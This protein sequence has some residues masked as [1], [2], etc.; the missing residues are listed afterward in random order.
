MRPKNFQLRI[1]IDP[2]L[3]LHVVVAFAQHGK[4]AQCKCKPLH[5]Y[6]T[7]YN[8][9]INCVLYANGVAASFLFSVKDKGVWERVKERGQQKAVLLLITYYFIRIVANYYHLH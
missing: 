3:D 8:E 5:R 9:Y 2:R 7:Q 1:S 4:Y 6:V